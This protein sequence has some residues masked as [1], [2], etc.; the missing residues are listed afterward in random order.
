M[1]PSK[2]KD[3]TFD[4]TSLYG[5]LKWA[6]L[7]LGHTVDNFHRRRQKLESEGFPC[8]DPLTNLYLKA[9]IDAWVESRRRKISTETANQLAGVNTNGL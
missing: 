8:R 5:S 2:C 4:D 7:R 6:A 3:H 9:D 1:E